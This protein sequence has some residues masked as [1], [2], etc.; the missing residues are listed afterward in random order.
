MKGF[1]LPAALRRFAGCLLIACLGVSSAPDPGK[2]AVW[3]PQ[4]ALG[5]HLRA[6]G[7]VAHLETDSAQRVV[8]R[9]PYLDGQA[10]LRLNHRLQAGSRWAMDTHYELVAL[11]GDTLESRSASI[12]AGAGLPRGYLPQTGV[13]DRRRLWDLTGNL[14]ETDRHLVYQ[15]LDRLHLSYTPD[16]G[17]LRLGRQALT[18][19]D[20]L[21]FN[22]MDLFN[23]FAPT[24]VQRD[25]K[26]GEDMLHLRW[27]LGAAD[28]EMLYLPRR[29]P[30]SGDLREDQGSTAV[31]LHLPI[32][33][34]E[35]DLMGARHYADSVVGVG[36]NG[37]LGA[38]LWRLNATYTQVA[39]GSVAD[40]YLQLVANLDTA[41]MWRGKNLYGLLEFYYNELG[42]RGDYASA[43]ADEVLAERLARGEIFTLG[44]Y[45]LAAQV[46]VEAHPLVRLDTTLIVNL[47]DPSGLV[48]PQLLWDLAEDWQMILGGQ[49]HWGARGSEFGGFTVDSPVDP[50]RLAPA[51]RLYL[52]LSRYF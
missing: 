13:D 37:Y 35:V 33:G 42:N 43:L 45:Y 16:W 40:N 49:W 38:A 9:D 29:D 31:K 26:T 5:G 17:S 23:P 8:D 51:D 41:W 22:P 30:E 24:A 34:L 4:M 10:E 15:R 14:S 7:S 47:W 46:Q 25:Y 20:G 1:P 21:I 36:G 12:G 52:W 27:L 6:I 18:W 32:S 48:Q 50:Q 44:Q 28:A 11:A 2:A 39:D 3:P 19:G